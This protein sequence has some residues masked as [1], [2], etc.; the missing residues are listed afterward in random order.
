MTFLRDLM[1]LLSLITRMLK[2]QFHRS[3]S[4]MHIKAILPQLRRNAI[5]LLV[6]RRRKALSKGRWLGS[7]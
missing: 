1:G 5:E 2:M 6:I 4:A 3:A 7:F